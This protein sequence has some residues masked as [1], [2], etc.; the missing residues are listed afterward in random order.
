MAL[1][2]AASIYFHSEIYPF[3][4]ACYRGPCKQSTHLKH[5]VRGPATTILDIYLFFHQN[6]VKF[7]CVRLWAGP[8]VFLSLS[9]PFDDGRVWSPWRVSFVGRHS[10]F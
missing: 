7:L 3:S 8:R 10:I 1:P 9:L 2:R 6:E 5:M 4:I